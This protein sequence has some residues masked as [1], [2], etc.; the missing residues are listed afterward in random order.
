M[1]KYI[2]FFIINRRLK[3]FSLLV[4]TLMIGLLEMLSIALVFPVLSLALEGEGIVGNSPS[5]MHKILNYYSQLAEYFATQEII[6]AS[7]TLIITAIVTYLS[8]LIFTWFQLVFST[9]LVLETKEN[10]FRKL[11]SLDFSFFVE[12]K[13]SSILHVLFKSTE[14][15]SSFT[16]SSIK[17]LSELIKVLFFLLLMMYIST[18]GTI[19][20]VLIGMFYLL[21]SKLIIN[22]IVIPTSSTMREKEKD[23]LQIISEFVNYVKEIRIYLQQERWLGLYIEKADQFAKNLRF[24]QFGASILSALPAMIII[25]AVGVVGLLMQG[26]SLGLSFASSFAT[27]FL[28]GQRINGSISMFLSQITAINSHRPNIDAIFSILQLPEDEK[29]LENLLKLPNW[30]KLIFKQVFFSYKSSKGHIVQNIDFTIQKN[31][32]IGLLGESGSGKSTLID[33]I[34]KVHNVSDGGIYF[35]ETSLDDISEKDFWSHIGFVGQNSAIVNGT[36]RDNILFGRVFEE[37]E[38]ISASKKS[39]VI[40]FIDDLDDGYNTQLMENGSNLSGGQK[41]RLMIARALISNP[42]ILILDEITSALDPI[43]EDKI[44]ELIKTLHGKTTILII[45]HNTFMT[46]YADTV[47]ALKNGELTKLP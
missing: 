26:F 18:I 45:T 28:A 37:D 36:L 4:V 13:S 23:Q 44:N 7:I 29:N 46:K 32:T 27:I 39:G 33:L 40:D 1:F 43:S 31:S 10:I 47:F 42:D 8:T 11:M 20:I 15:L 25:V 19:L 2:T 6:I 3:A 17:A 35:D 21:V 12:T 9:N 14:S 24:N 41:Q 30:K 5:G 22:K 16:E 34:L 38:I